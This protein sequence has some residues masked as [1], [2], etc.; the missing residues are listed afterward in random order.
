MVSAAGKKMP[1]LVSP[2]VVIDGV[3]TAPAAKVAVDDADIVVAATELGV[4]APNVPFITAPVRVL[5]VSVSVVA[6]PI[7]VSVAAGSVRV[8]VPATAVA[9]NVVVPDVEPE[10]SI[11]LG[12]RVT[13]VAMI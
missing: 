1:V 10:I 11:A 9:C 5:F 4:V 6:L 2:V 8:V 13:V 7:K 3:P 12:L